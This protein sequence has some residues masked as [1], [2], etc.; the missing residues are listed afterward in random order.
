[1]LFV[2]ALV[3]ALVYWF[4]IRKPNPTPPACTLAADCSSSVTTKDPNWAAYIYDSNCQCIL[5]GCKAGFKLS[6]GVCVAKSGPSPPPGPGPTPCIPGIPCDP[7]TKVPNG[8]SYTYDPSCNCRVA[9]CAGSF[10]AQNGACVTAPWLAINGLVNGETEDYVADSTVVKDGAACDTYMQNK[11]D[12][13][14]YDWDKNNSRCV[15]FTDY[16]SV[17]GYG[18]MESHYINRVMP[19]ASTMTYVRPFAPSNPEMGKEQMAY[20]E[21]AKIKN[22]QIKP[23]DSCYGWPQCKSHCAGDLKCQAVTCNGDGRNDCMM[24]GGNI[25]YATDVG[26]DDSTWAFLKIPSTLTG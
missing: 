18:S 25:N 6:N 12:V 4:F 10:V 19:D 16:R 13:M 2:V 9:T 20:V 21:G 14:V 11:Q 24:Y 17:S 22:T 5:S 8:V 7:T 3:A 1:M 23:Y 15:G 26:P